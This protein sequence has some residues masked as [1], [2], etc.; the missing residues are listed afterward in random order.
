MRDASLF[1]LHVGGRKGHKVVWL[2]NSRGSA[3]PT[4][5]MRIDKLNEPAHCEAQM[6]TR[7]VLCIDGGGLGMYCVFVVCC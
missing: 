5:R 6:R 1:E 7:D 3:L 2:R 4:A